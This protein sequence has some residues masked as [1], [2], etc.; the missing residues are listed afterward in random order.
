MT[1]SISPMATRR[2]HEDDREAPKESSA[3][4]NASDK[5]TTPRKPAAH[6]GSRRRRGPP[7][8]W[9][10]SRDSS[11]SAYPASMSTMLTSIRA[12]AAGV[13][14]RNSS[15]IHTAGSPCRASLAPSG[16]ALEPA[17]R[18]TKR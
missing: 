14:D 6:R 1:T 17:P 5:A 12:S 10:R 18:A 16:R 13:S 15:R 2:A 4:I 7:A 11:A 8:R 9:A 3:A